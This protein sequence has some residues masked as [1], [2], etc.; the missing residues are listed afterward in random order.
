MN[1]VVLGLADWLLRRTLPRGEAGDTIRGDL[2]E[3]L[4]GA[5]RT[6]TARRRYLRHACSL[7]LRFR[8]ERPRSNT[9]V[10]P[11]TGG[12]PM[13]GSIGYDIRFAMR[14]LARRPMFTLMTLAT[15]GLG[16]GA[17]T[18]IFSIVNGILLRP[19][20]FVQPER[21]VAVNETDGVERMTFAMPNYV[22]V[23]G[24]ATSFE[25]MACHQS[26]AFDVIDGRPRRISGRLVSAEFF[27]VLGIGPQLGRSF[28]SEDDRVGALP[29]AVVSDRYWRQDSVA[30]RGCSAARFGRRSRRSRLSA[31]C[32]PITGSPDPRTST[33]RL[34]RLSRP[35]P[36]GSTV[37]IISDSTRWRG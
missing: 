6:R 7:V 29:V 25:T 11:S 12:R 20:P 30:T 22:D 35:A 26:E 5:G 16:I 10:N 4:E 36:S 27:D 21:L 14:S 3:E 31:C 15:L 28:T 17:A 19:L 32:R 33:R 13:W 9:L 24:R 34:A 8:L 18:A 2:I 23:H 1:D 37:A